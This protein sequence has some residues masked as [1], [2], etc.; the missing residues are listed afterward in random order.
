MTDCLRDH[1]VHRHGAQVEQASPVI[2][3]HGDQVLPHSPASVERQS[4]SAA[5]GPELQQDRASRCGGALP[6]ADRVQGADLAA[7]R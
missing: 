6:R 3:G 4:Q 1:A 2:S 7:G 5:A